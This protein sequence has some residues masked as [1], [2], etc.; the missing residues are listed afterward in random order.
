MAKSP[1]NQVGP[2]PNSL[3]QPYEPGEIF[4]P[5][6]AVVFVSHAH[7]GTPIYMNFG[8]GDHKVYRKL[9]TP[10]HALTMAA[11]LIEAA[12]REL[13]HPPKSLNGDKEESSR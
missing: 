10:Q 9:I 5:D 1:A 6:N 7:R 8:V 4:L 2:L 13:C 3:P 11:M 12:Q